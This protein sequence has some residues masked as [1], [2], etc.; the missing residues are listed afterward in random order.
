VVQKETGKRNSNRLFVVMG[1]S[2]DRLELGGDIEA[3]VTEQGAANLG[4]AFRLLHLATSQYL[5]FGA[6]V[7][8]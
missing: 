1:P 2:A 5:T 7:R 4:D 8:A 6:Q 3:H